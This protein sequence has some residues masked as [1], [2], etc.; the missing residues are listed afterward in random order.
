MSEEIITSRVVAFEDAADRGFLTIE[1]DPDRNGGKFSFAPGDTVNLDVITSADIVLTFASQGSLFFSGS[2]ERPEEEYI[3]V[4]QEGS[5]NLRYPPLNFSYQWLGPDAGNVT[6]DGTTL[7]FASEETIGLLKVNY[8]IA[9]LWYELRDVAQIEQIMVAMLN[10]D[11]RDDTLLISFQ[12]EEEEDNEVSIIVRDY[13]TGNPVAGVDVNV[14]GEFKGTTDADGRVYI[15]KQ[16]Q[17]TYALLLEP[18]SPYLQ[19]DEDGLAN[20]EYTIE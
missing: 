14:D 15:G 3:P 16:A 2:T 11:G 18:P 7:N 8:D 9:L 13:S 1:I 10:E 12:A 4:F 6:V 19:S 5:K 20:D 17:G